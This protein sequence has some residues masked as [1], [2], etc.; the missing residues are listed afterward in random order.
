[1]TKS[2]E[3]AIDVGFDG[4]KKIK[5]RK[6]QVLV[7]IMGFLI[8]IRI[9]PAHIHDIEGAKL[10]FNERYKDKNTLLRIWADGSYKSRS[11]QYWLKKQFKITLEIVKSIKYTG[12]I[13][14]KYY[15]DKNQLELFP[16]N[17]IDRKMEVKHFK[18][19]GW[20]WIVEK[21]LSWLRKNRRLIVDYERKPTSSEGFCYIAMIRHMLKRLNNFK[22]L[23]IAA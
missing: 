16:V 8:Y 6:R 22:T 15:Y 9:H 12:Y 17:K 18:I 11:F 2:T 1:M 14:K 21:T 19:V 4:N 20:R 10:I 7:D 3:E 23:K 5:E 13:P